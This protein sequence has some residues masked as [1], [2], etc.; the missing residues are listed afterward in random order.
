MHFPPADREAR[1]AS[2]S[3]TVPHRPPIPR[4]NPGGPQA[5]QHRTRSQDAH[6][7]HLRPPTPPT[8]RP[9]PEPPQLSRRLVCP[10]LLAVGIVEVSGG[11][12]QGRSSCRG[13]IR[14][15]FGAGLCI[16]WRRA[17]PD[18][19]T[20]PQVRADAAGRVGTH[21]HARYHTPRVNTS[22]QADLILQ[23]SRGHRGAWPRHT[24]SR[25]GQISAQTGPLV[26]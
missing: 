1:L 6:A 9:E 8:A 13:G 23:P 21:S 19:L 5:S 22:S 16:W 26:T 14:R 18:A 10:V 24:A 17:D 11:A 2:A 12:T 7:S 3:T 4:E 25:S 15:R 20:N